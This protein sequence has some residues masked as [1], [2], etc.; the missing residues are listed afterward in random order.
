MP[1]VAVHRLGILPY[2]DAWELQEKLFDAKINYKLHP[3]IPL[4][5]NKLLICE[6]PPV[7]TLGKSGS[8]SHLLLNENELIQR[9]IS[10][11]RNNRGGDITFHGPGQL[12]LYPILDLDE[13]FTDL[14]K[15]MRFL[16][17]VVIRTLL[18]Y[19]IK[20]ERLLGATGVWLDADEPFKARKICAMGVRTSRWV[21]MHG[22]ALN[23]N[24]N[25]E[26]FK[27]IIPCGIA[28]K[29]VTS[30]QNELGKEV[31]LQEV[32]E[33]LVKHFAQVFNCE[34]IDNEH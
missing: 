18:E 34:I 3:E 11:F 28:D 15:Y 19:N 26:Y 14:K 16:E 7:Y 29:S 23:V 9:N 22:L 8:I 1:S 17:E 13:F 10:F 5:T 24:T 25:L 12:V 31:P 32:S 6:H 30:L 33:K 21:T 27:H 20:G 4:E 2:K